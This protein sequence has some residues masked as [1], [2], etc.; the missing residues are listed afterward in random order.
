MQNPVDRFWLNRLTSV[1]DRLKS[2][3]F[4]VFL[5]ENVSEAKKIVM[6]KILSDTGAKS[7]AW[8]G[9]MTL[10]AI[11]LCDAIRSNTAFDVFDPFD[12]NASREEAAEAR[13]RA[14]T[15]D[16]FLSG[17][18]A[19]TEKGQ[20]VNL[21][22]T[23]NRV[24]AIAYGPKNVVILVGRN[25]IVT[26]L[27]AAFLRIKSFAAPANALRLKKK[28]PCVKTSYC[29]EC[30]SPERLCNTWVVSEKSFPKGRIKIVLI[31]ENL[32]L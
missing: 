7:V 5:A 2:N 14:L 17:T 30:N 19:V 32:G 25:K 15:A 24:G 28:T 10:N 26:D 13:S 1:A 6:G 29:E 8:G 31:N 18:N 22:M 3:N 12:K 4:D 20:L 16:L 27:E 11:G 23:G 21:D 9:S